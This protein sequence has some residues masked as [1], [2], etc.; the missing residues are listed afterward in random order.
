MRL[1]SYGGDEAEELLQALI[2]GRNYDR[3]DEHHDQNDAGCLYDLGEGRPRHPF[4]LGKYFLQFFTH[5]HEDIGFFNFLICHFDPPFD[6]LKLRGKL[7]G[8]LMLG[9]LLAERA[10][11][12]NG[13]P[14]GIV[15]LVLVAVVISVLT[16]GAFE[17]DFSPC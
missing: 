11:F 9:V 16:F 1:L 5:S 2:Y 10:V 15:A 17:S 8:F 14:V 4:K 13:K 12:G 3:E 6:A 7:L